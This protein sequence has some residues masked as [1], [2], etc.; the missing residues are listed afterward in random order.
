M[1]EQGESIQRE[2]VLDVIMRKAFRHKHWSSWHRTEEH[3]DQC[4]YLEVAEDIYAAMREMVEQI[5]RREAEERALAI[6]QA[7]FDLDA[8]IRSGLPISRE[9][10]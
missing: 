9:E 7:A 10:G 3:R 1:P 2:D 5:V 8:S 4:Q 6:L